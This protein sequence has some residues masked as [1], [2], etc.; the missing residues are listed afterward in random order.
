MYKSWYFKIHNLDQSTP[1]SAVAKARRIINGL[2][3]IELQPYPLSDNQDKIT[4][5][6]LTVLVYGGNAKTNQ[7]QNCASIPFAPQ[8]HALNGGWINIRLLGAKDNAV[9]KAG[10][11]ALYCSCRGQ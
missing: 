11:K 2:P 3:D 5:P 4:V 9:W 10:Y 8:D 1:I 7:N 6:K